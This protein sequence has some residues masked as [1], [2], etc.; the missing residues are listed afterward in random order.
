MGRCRRRLATAPAVG[1]LEARFFATV[2]A[3]A[4]RLLGVLGRGDDVAVDD[5]RSVCD[6]DLGC[7][8]AKY[9]YEAERTHAAESIAP[10]F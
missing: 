9:R 3:S 7:R 5:V 10:A 8:S 2:P 4:A 1:A 6:D